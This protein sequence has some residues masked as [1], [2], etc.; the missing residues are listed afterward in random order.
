[1]HEIYL[2][3][4]SNLGDRQRYL[5][6]GRQYIEQEIGPI[7]KVSALYETAPWGNSDQ[8]AFLNQALLVT[9]SLSPRDLLTTIHVIEKLLGRD[10]TVKWGARTL[11]IDILFYGNLVVCEA[12]LNIP[13]PLL[14]ERRFALTPLAEIAPELVHP[15][16]G[17]KIKSLLSQLTDTLS[18]KRFDNT[19][20]S[21]SMNNRTPEIDLSYLND[22]AGGNAEF[23]IEMIDIFLQ[24]TPAYFEELMQAVHEKNWKTTGDV[25]HK[26]KPTFAFIGVEDARAGMAELERKARQLDGVE[27]IPAMASGLFEMCELLYQNLTKIKTELTDKAGS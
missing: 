27:E 10:R 5:L 15:V 23:M 18:V 17:I 7:G 1:M 26:I 22:I 9:S 16:S 21:K 12:D 2:L 13:H 8:P 6:Q 20:I 19:E 4:G 14:A 3:L 11:D 25:A 24:Q